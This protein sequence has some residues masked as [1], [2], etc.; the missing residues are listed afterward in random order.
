MA[1]GAQWD[2]VQTFGWTRMVI[3]YSRTMDVFQAIHRTFSGEMC[4]ICHAVNDAK[5]QEEHSA[6]P[7]R[8]LDAKA[9]CVFQPAAKF[10][11]ATTSLYRWPAGDL[12]PAAAL[13]AAPPTPPPR[14]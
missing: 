11:F 14:A 4:K 1:T 2:V 10:I 3:N 12:E 9:F 5:Q 8:K 7:T 6:V 13:R